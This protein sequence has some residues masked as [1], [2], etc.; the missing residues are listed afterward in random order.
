MPN[1]IITCIG[2]AALIVPSF[3]KGDE[4]TKST[5]IT[6][7]PTISAS[8]QDADIEL[9]TLLRRRYEAAKAIMDA[10]M[11]YYRGGRVVP[12]DVLDAIERFT[13]AGLEYAETPA[14]QVQTCEL[15]LSA[16]KEV[17][18]VIRQKFEDK[19]EPIQV[20]ERAKYTRLDVEIQ[21]FRVRKAA[22]AAED[23]K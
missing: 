7:A 6:E 18:Q 16:A 10:R 17:E 15:A 14:K 4:P 5:A 11:E 9:Q 2:I 22:K 19:I 8:S 13:K 1:L 21:L 20:T 12:D 3:S 23:K